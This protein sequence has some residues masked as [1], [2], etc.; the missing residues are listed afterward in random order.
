M[1]IVAF[2]LTP[3]NGRDTVA[4]PMPL[5]DW[6]ASSLTSHPRHREMFVHVFAH[7]VV[8]PPLI[9][10]YYLAQWYLPELS[11]PKTPS[12]WFQFAEVALI[13]FISILPLLTCLFLLIS[14]LIEVLDSLFSIW[15]KV[16]RRRRA[17]R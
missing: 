15:D 11:S 17:G 13:R 7:A 12:D 16:K 9:G 1:G 10:L 14:I 4:E 6:L 2:Y 5:I 3:K 8:I